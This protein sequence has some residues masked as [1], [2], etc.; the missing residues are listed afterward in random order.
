MP[1]A[2][3][4]SLPKIG[5]FVADGAPADAG[6]L[7]A[8]GRRFAELLRIARRH[9]LLPFRKLDFTRDPATSE[10]RARQ[11]EGLRRGLEEAGGAF[12]KIGQLLSTRDD[13]LPDEWMT[14]LAHLQRN[15]APASWDSVE[16]L[17]VTDLGAPI[18]EVFRTFDVEPVA[19]ASIAQVHRATLRDGQS[20]AVKIQRPGIVA[21][22]K[23]DVDIAL[24]VTR[25]LARTSPQARRLGV[26][27]VAAQYADDLVRQVDF[28]LEAVNLAALRSTQAKSPRADELRLP[29]LHESLSTGRVLVM[30]YVEGETLS[31]VRQNRSAPAGLEATMRTILRAFIR[32]VVFDG[33][34]H[35]DLH[36]GNILLTDDG[37]PALVDFG[38]VGRLDMSL[39]ETVQ[40]LLIAYL[41]SDTRRIADSVLMMAPLPDPNQEPG[42]RR[43]LATFV[44]Y[45]LGPG[46]RVGIDTV[47]AAVEVFAQYGMAV[48]A[49]FVA[50][51]RAFAILDGTLRSLVPEFDLLEESK[52]LAGEQAGDQLTVKNVRDL[53][54]REVLGVLPGIRRL[55]R[56]ID[57]IGEALESGTLNVNVRLLADRR[58][59]RLLVGIVRQVLLGAVGA[60]FGVLA[61]VYLAMP[62]PEPR[63]AIGTA[64][65]GVVLMIAA[66]VALGAAVVDV[67][68]TR[69]R[70]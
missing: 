56:R 63:G 40:E 46:S 16:A 43:D 24:R 28:R 15:V 26:E 18:H 57:R 50:A 33:V 51:G 3:A 30:E 38:S 19:A 25:F 29:E 42:F 11:A 23:R 41:Q 68:R 70:S 9:G 5:D 62:Q 2:R 67:V 64:T 53:V 31:A 10:L 4:A 37:R 55:P 45:H 7:R 60:G 39:R 32:Q 13:L 1:A 54:L 27:D 22:V 48:P 34:F 8:R 44:T 47:D 20:V 65:V 12:V 49:D 69:S 36:P 59:R 61:L 14:A 17:L 21:V 58:D 52:A 6:S 35:A 66:V